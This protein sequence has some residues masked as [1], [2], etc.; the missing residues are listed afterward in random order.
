MRGVTGIGFGQD[1]DHWFRCWHCGFPCNE[2]REALGGP[3]QYH[4]SEWTRYTTMSIPVLGD[5]L[6]AKMTV[7]GIQQNVVLMELGADGVTEKEVP[8]AIM[9]A[10]KQGCPLCGTLNWRGDY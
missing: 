10:P 8:E 2:D 3:D 4:E 7:G 5:E 9:S 6:S 1:D